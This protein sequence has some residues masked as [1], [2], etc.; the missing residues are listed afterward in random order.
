[1]KEHV[2]KVDGGKY[3]FKKSGTVIDI[4]RCGEPWHSLHDAFHALES[5]MFE[6][7]AARAVLDA[8]RRLGD[9]AP[10]E[11]NQALALHSALVDDREPPT[12][13]SR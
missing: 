13:W 11:I 7:D 5:M 3:T 4:E 12:E 9:D 2:I 1:M 6:L 8:C 10:R